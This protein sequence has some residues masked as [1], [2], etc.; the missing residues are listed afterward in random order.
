LTN[1]FK[2]TP[3]GGRISVSA[4]RDKG[5]IKVEVADTGAGISE[6][7]LERIFE[8]YYIAEDD[9]QLLSGLGIGLSLAKS[10]VEAHGGRIWAESEQGKGSKFTFVLPV[11]DGANA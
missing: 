5:S 8:R 4:A 7:R 1:A 10:I 11:E 6:D 3:G 2:W 9:G